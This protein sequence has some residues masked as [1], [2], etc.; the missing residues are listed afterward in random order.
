MLFEQLEARLNSSTFPVIPGDINGDNAITIADV[1][2]VQN[3][4]NKD[5]V[6]DVD[7]DGRTTIADFLD[8]QNNFNLRL[9]MTPNDFYP[10]LPT[11]G[12]VFTMYPGASLLGADNRVSRDDFVQGPINDC[13]T[14]AAWASNPQAVA[15]A[16]KPD[17][18]AGWYVVKMGTMFIHVDSSLPAWEH[19]TTDGAIIGGIAEK[20]EAFYRTQ[21]NT[22]ASLNSGLPTEAATPFGWTYTPYYM[23]SW[24]ML[25][26][27]IDAGQPVTALTPSA[28]ELVTTHV[29]TVV[30]YSV[31]NGT[32]WLTLRNPWGIDGPMG[33]GSNDGYITITF[34]TYLRSTSLTFM[35]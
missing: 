19:P 16:I 1:L 28:T 3:H 25:V 27:R 2:I 8:I 35:E 12:G 4:F 18:V 22:Y 24:S 23:P 17:V 31:I 7:G 15:D 30:G 10:G 6:G 14:F 5:A 9:A 21:A 11:D 29:Y 32:Q 26:A 33:D 34:S 13:W 20:A